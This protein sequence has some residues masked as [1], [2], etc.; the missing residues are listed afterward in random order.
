[1]N[2]LLL[3]ESVSANSDLRETV[4]S[5]PSAGI[6]LS[7]EIVPDQAVSVMIGL[8]PPTVYLSPSISILSSPNPV[9]EVAAASSYQW[10]LKDLRTT[11]SSPDL[12]G[13][14]LN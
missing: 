6:V 14:I 5:I 7:G 3:V 4:T 13:L 1:L 2:A 8:D 10:K 12:D 9:R 11:S